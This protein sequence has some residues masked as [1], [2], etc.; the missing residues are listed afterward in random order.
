MIIVI[1]KVLIA[2]FF[3]YLDF[4]LIIGYLLNFKINKAKLILSSIICALSSLIFTLSNI[5]NF[6]LTF[7]Q[8]IMCLF[9]LSFS[10]KNL[11]F[12]QL[13]QAYIALF[14]ISNI[15]YNILSTFSAKIK[16][17]III[18][19][20]IPMLICIGIIMILSVLIKKCFKLVLYK[21]KQ[22]HNIYQL[23]LFYKGKSFTT[24]GFYDTG[25]NLTYNN[26]PV[27]IITFDLY[28]Q[29]TNTTLTD[30]LSND[31]EQKY[32]DVGTITGKQKLAL[33]ILEKLVIS[34]NNQTKIIE[35]PQFAL[36]LKFFNKNN[37]DII[38]NN[39]CL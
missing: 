21:Q 25:N 17:G 13:A 26:E 28:S 20:P 1:E 36:S 14:L 8:I 31:T 32:I 18:S 15:Y 29:L 37:Y 23:T 2:N 4:I 12:K 35:N 10:Y 33:L 6:L 38:L 30:Y 16:N 11:S 22:K 19:T 5:S 24:N 9:V 39:N 7:Y 27:S 3:L 34:I